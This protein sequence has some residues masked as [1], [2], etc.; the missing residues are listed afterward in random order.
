M[1]VER[2]G[3]QGSAGATSASAGAASPAAA[4]AREAVAPAGFADTLAGVERSQFTA[5]LD[6]LVRRLDEQGQVLVKRQTVT[7]LEKY[8]ELVT[9]FL[10]RVVKD[11]Y[12][13]EEIPSAF[14]LQNNKVFVYARKVEEKLALLAE[15]VRRGN[16][17]ALSITA[18]TSEIRGLLLDLRG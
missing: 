12:R 10:S 11:A 6:D 4:R 15:E 2:E 9:A 7:E 16:A 18:A 3:K 17:D 8:R 5:E 1:K 13:V 14:F